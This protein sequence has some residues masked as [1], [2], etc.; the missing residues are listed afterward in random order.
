MKPLFYF[1]RP[2]ASIIVCVLA[3]ASCAGT[4]QV[5]P[6]AIPAPRQS[7]AVTPL[8]DQAR[9]DAAKGGEVS[10]RL[11]SKVE[12]LQRTTGELRSGMAMATAEA[13]RLRK[14][15]AATENELD[16][17]WQMLN[18]TE[19]RAVA[20]FAEVESAKLIADEQKAHRVIAEKRLDE[21]A[22]AAIARDNETLEL[23]D[24]R[25]H[26]AAELDK[27]GKVH[28]DI[29]A[30]LSK[31]EMKAAV[32]TYLKGIVWF[33]GIVLVLIVAVRVIAFFKPL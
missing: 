8:V 16:A 33:I 21:L 12:S 26:Y 28:A 31:A 19:A 32:G 6:K 3:V 11:E 18:G 27:A 7:M 24:Q 17:L 20:L 25:D 9:A 2:I 22:K 4:T 1:I 13:D 29:L 14:Q 30:K 23:R 15:K 5:P 10:S